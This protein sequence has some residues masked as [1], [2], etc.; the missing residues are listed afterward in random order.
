MK[1]NVISAA[2]NQAIAEQRLVGA[3][4]V[5][6]RNGAVW[7][8]ESF[9]LADREYA[10]PMNANALFRYSS[11][12][13]PIVTAAA[14]VLVEQGRLHLQVPVERWLPDFRPL[15][16]DGTPAS[17]TVHHLLT[18]TAGLTYRL[19]E[20][21]GPYAAAGVSDGL[22]RSGISMTEELRR[23]ASVPLSFRPGTAWGYSVAIDV[24]GEVV[25]RAN[26]T[27]L[28][29]AVGQLVT[30]P[31]GMADTG[32]EVRD[33][34]RLTAHYIDGPPPKLMR[35]PEVVP[36]RDG[37]MTTFSPTRAFDKVSFPSGG[38]GMIGSTD[39]FVKFLE[40]LRRGGAPI[41]K[42]GTVR[43]MMN[44]QI[45]SLRINTE[46]TPAWGF[47]YG[48]AVLMDPKLGQTP[49]PAGT[50]RW[51][52]VYGHQWFIDPQNH[53]TVVVQTNTT[54][55]GFCGKFVQELRDAVYR[56]L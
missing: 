21:N 4:V 20:P 50:W 28:P 10:A 38:A 12:T 45:G 6:L 22:D 30:G 39:D 43:E 37:G 40:T 17:I 55:E 23:I 34:S 11:F 18:H 24:V 16:P 25:A 3:N 26:G 7:H 47:G 13:K 33:V 2:V 14:M 32:F 48:G 54:L 46:P 1:R 35:D 42:P 8:R 52:G 36:M 9:G 53:L 27:S 51:A 44:N 15:N 49:Q 56:S 19:I 31:L 29:E 41:L 5:V